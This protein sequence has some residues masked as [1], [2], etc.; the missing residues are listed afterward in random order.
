MALEDIGWKVLV[1]WECE[2]ID[3][4]RSDALKRVLENFINMG[5]DSSLINDDLGIKIV[6]YST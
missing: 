5:L 4:I 2:I 3:P 1:V 6:N